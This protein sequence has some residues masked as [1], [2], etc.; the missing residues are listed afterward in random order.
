MKIVIAPDSFKESLPAE[1]VA[2]AIHEGFIESFPDAEYHL[3][4]IGD[5]G[6]GTMQ[7]LASANQAVIE[8]VSVTGPLSEPVHAKIA[9]SSDGKK[10]YIEMAEASGLHLVPFERRNPLN[11][12]TFGVGELIVHAMDSG[13][14]ELVIGVGGS[15]TNDGGIGMAAALGY[16][17]YDHEGALVRGIGQDLFH[18]ESMTGEHRDPRLDKVKITIAADVENPLTGSNGATYVYGPQ[19]GLKK[20]MLEE[21]DSALGRFY[22]K[23]CSNFNKEI[24]SIPGSGAGGGIAAGLLLFTNAEIKK[25]IELVLEELDV[26]NICKDA[27]LV[28]VG[29]GRM[30]GQTLNGKAPLGVAACSPAS[31]RVIAI[32]GSIGDGSEKLYKHG[33]H[34]VFPTIP[35]L[36]PV[37]RI[38]NDAYNNIKRTARNIAALL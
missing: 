14:T 31:S 25:G 21:V 23:A 30:D 20:E 2:K 15:A 26:K 3:L 7:S 16:R 11:A 38:M 35:A 13:A 5:G 8:T 22:E 27:D 10:A 18:I 1:L 32:C 36:L 12:T 17:F 9:F 19:K 29:E 28:I 34:A 6:E 33:I 4:P 37:E 24:M